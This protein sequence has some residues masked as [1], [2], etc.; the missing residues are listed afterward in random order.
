AL[1]T[2][3]EWQLEPEVLRFDAA[4][5]VL[6][7]RQLMVTIPKNWASPAPRFAIAA[8]VMRDG[9]YLGQITEA[10]VDMKG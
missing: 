10:V 5:G 1:V 4:P 8:D 2:P 7:T 3:A 9:K 6:T